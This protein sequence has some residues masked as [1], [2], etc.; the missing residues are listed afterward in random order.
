[1]GYVAMSVL[2]KDDD[3]VVRAAVRS[4]ISDRRFH[5]LPGRGGLNPWPANDASLV[6]PAMEQQQFTGSFKER[7]ARWLNPRGVMMQT[8]PRGRDAGLLRR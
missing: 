5:D 7:G 4:Q 8:C 3:V 1:M 2:L 6:A